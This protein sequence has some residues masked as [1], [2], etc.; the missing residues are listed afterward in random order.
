MLANFNNNND[1]KKHGIYE[2]SPQSHRSWI[3]HALEKKTNL[4]YYILHYA[5]MSKS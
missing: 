3:F 2:I 5:L 4:K 1:S